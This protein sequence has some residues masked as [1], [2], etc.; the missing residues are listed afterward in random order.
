MSKRLGKI[1]TALLWVLIVISAVLIVLL[2]TNI[3]DN[4]VDPTM[5]SWVNNNLYW[6]YVLLAIGAGIA[7]LASIFT[8]FTNG[9]AAKRGLVSILFLVAVFGVAYVFASDVIPQFPGSEK[10][11]REG[12]LTSNIIKIVETG[13]YATYLLLGIAILSIVSSTVVRLFK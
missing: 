1:S 4:K 9:K 2:F 12:V 8:M 5:G 3:S 13:L 7:V 10:L 11:V 6:T